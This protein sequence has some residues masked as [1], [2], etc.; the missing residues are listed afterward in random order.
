MRCSGS[1]SG[2]RA[3]GAVVRVVGSVRVR[4]FVRR[5][6]GGGG[7]RFFGVRAV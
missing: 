3:R 6:K 2:R 4:V 5:G 7:V 1:G